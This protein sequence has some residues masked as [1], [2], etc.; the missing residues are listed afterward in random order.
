MISTKALFSSRLFT[1]STES[2]HGY[3]FKY[4]IPL[5]SVKKFGG[6]PRSL[7]LFKFG[8]IIIVSV[9]LGRPV[10]SKLIRIVSSP[11]DSGFPSF[12]VT[13][14]IETL[15]ALPPTPGLKI[16]LAKWAGS[17][18]TPESAL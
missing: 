5:L 4:R 9:P 15:V 14:V 11:P 17:I 3:L 1:D 8:G 6:V 18:V 7:I 10:T 16:I 2:I 13:P 12:F